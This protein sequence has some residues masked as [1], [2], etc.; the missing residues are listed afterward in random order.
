M[1]QLLSPT[2]TR[3]ATAT[4]SPHTVT[5]A[6]PA[7]GA[8]S[9]PAHTARAL[10]CSIADSL[11]ATPKCPPT[12]RVPSRGTP[13]VPAPL[14]LSPFSP[15]DRDS[16]CVVWKGFPAFPAH[17]R[18]RPV[19]RGNSRRVCLP[20]FTEL[21]SSLDH[22]NFANLKQNSFDPAGLS[23]CSGGLRPLVELCV[24]P[25]GLCGRCR[26]SR[27]QLCATS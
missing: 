7:H 11:P 27:V 1:P 3:E 10:G 20:L 2:C 6:A 19:S 22:S 23:S 24:D 15:P 17:L 14:P 8:C 9:L 25:A 16:P 21:Q 18:M 5:R 12:R 13:T 26:F 4:R